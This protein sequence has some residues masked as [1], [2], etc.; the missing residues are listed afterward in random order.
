VHH[1]LHRNFL[2]NHI[3]C[4]LLIKH[5]CN[6]S[7]LCWQEAAIRSSV[8]QRARCII[9]YTATKIFIWVRLL[10]KRRC[11][12]KI[13]HV[14]K[15]ALKNDRKQPAVVRAFR[16]MDVGSRG[17]FSIRD[18]RNQGEEHALESGISRILI[19]STFLEKLYTSFDPGHTWS[20]TFFWIVTAV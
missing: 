3:W 2:K 5:K 4:F 14:C 15:R 1:K 12:P 13:H 17:R 6:R 11:S 20:C 7:A 10:I 19:A 18:A 8:W 16:R 9:G